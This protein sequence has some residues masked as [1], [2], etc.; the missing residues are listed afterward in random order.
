[1]TASRGRKGR[2]IAAVV[3]WVAASALLAA[4]GP[5]LAKRFPEKQQFVLEAQRPEDPHAT[6]V[7]KSLVVRPFRAS[8][9]L[10]GVK[11]VYKTGSGTYESDFYHVFWT[12]PEAMIADEARRWLEASGLFG[13]VWD[14]RSVL[15]PALM[16]EG[17]VLE[18]YADYTTGGPPHAILA[19][20]FAL[21]DVEQPI[22]TVAF[23]ADYRSDVAAKADTPE[24]IVAAW[25]A[26]LGDVL[27][28]FET[29][30]ATR[31]L[32]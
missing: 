10:D 29:D 22:P 6:Q 12:A 18:L 24:A 1:V 3:G 31:G 7:G 5:L 32:R 25:N 21:V 26:A 15:P 14:A 13:S 27:T 23:H 28:R 17:G 30:L 20:S 16:L 4:C 8:P 2:R 19:V 9:R 11:F